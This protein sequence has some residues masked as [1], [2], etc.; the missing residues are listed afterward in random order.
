MVPSPFNRYGDALECN[1]PS[2]RRARVEEKY[3]P[4]DPDERLVLDDYIQVMRD[5][6][7]E[8][9]VLIDPTTGLG[10]NLITP[11]EIQLTGEERAAKL[12]QLERAL[13]PLAAAARPPLSKGVLLFR[14]LRRDVH[15]TGPL[16]PGFYARH[17]SEAWMESVEDLWER[18][19]TW[20]I[21]VLSGTHDR[22][23]AIAEVT[24]TLHGLADYGVLAKALP[25]QLD[26]ERVVRPRN[27]KQ[28]TRGRKFIIEALRALT[29]VAVSTITRAIRASDERAK[30]QGDDGRT[31]QQEKLRRFLRGE[32]QAERE[33]ERTRQLGLKR[34]ESAP[35][36]QIR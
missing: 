9:D 21:R 12:L 34:I 1:M 6:L 30:R 5:A 35:R 31:V 3:P 4:I 17:S 26:V 29:G 8:R 2:G 11:E 22:A 32:H 15:P 23:L 10:G 25:R 20:T 27:Q 24:I 36:R 14:L 33:E 28:R 7:R 18:A 16:P 13:M 19:A